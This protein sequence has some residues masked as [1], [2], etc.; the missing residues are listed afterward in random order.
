MGG[1][2]IV[3]L[4][5]LGDYV[6]YILMVVLVV[7]MIMVLIGMFDWNFVVMIYKVLKGNVFVMIVIVVVV[8]II[9]NLGLGV[10]IGIV[11]SVVLFVFNMVKIYVKYLYIEN[12]KIYE[13]YG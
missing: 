7:V 10:I 6:V 2:L 4:F 8:F 5:V 1:F 3:L 9:Y 13:I 12:K 11:I